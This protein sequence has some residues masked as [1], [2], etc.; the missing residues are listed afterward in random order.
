M[1]DRIATEDHRGFDFREDLMRISEDRI[2]NHALQVTPVGAGLVVLS[3]RFG[4]PE[5]GR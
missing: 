3:R 1:P 2:P 5:L 4:V